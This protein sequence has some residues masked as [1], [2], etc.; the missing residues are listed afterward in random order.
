MELHVYKSAPIDDAPDGAGGSDS[1]YIAFR[2]YELDARDKMDPEYPSENVEKEARNAWER[3]PYRHDFVRRLQLADEKVSALEVPHAQN[4]RNLEDALAIITESAGNPSINNVVTRLNARRDLCRALQ[5]SY[6]ARRQYGDAMANFH[7]CVFEAD[8]DGNEF[9]SVRAR[10]FTTLHKD[11]NTAAEV[12]LQHR[13]EVIRAER[14]GMGS[15]VSS[16]VDLAGSAAVPS[17]LM[18]VGLGKSAAAGGAKTSGGIPIAEPPKLIS[19]ETVPKVS[20]DGGKVVAGAEETKLPMSKLR[21]TDGKKAT[22]PPT[23]GPADADAVP[24]PAI[25]RKATSDGDDKTSAKRS[26]AGGGPSDEWSRLE[27]AWNNFIED[28]GN[29]GAMN[30]WIDRYNSLA[31]RALAIQRDGGP[32]IFPPNRAKHT[33]MN[34]WRILCE[35]VAEG[36]YPGTLELWKNYLHQTY[37]GQGGDAYIRAKQYFDSMMEQTGKKWPP[38]DPPAGEWTGWSSLFNDR[39]SQIGFGAEIGRQDRKWELVQTIGSGGQGHA[40]L[41][42]QS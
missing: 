26:G 10:A 5:E 25:K 37:Q 9:S 31:Y 3:H 36:E 34:L 11:E 16:A 22:A 14:R 12:Q 27:T 28:S 42:V 23:K 38:I 21:L 8:D 15:R 13:I 2:N 18:S 6:R 29:A 17:A 19:I 32:A 7:A 41:Y 24:K 40:D 4:I 20:M 1:G 35:V 39:M 33:D 30:L